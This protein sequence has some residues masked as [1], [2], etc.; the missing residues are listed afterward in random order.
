MEGAKSL[1]PANLEASKKIARHQNVEKNRH[2]AAILDAQKRC[3][4]REKNYC[5]LVWSGVPYRQALSEAY[6][7][8]WLD[9][10]DAQ[11]QSR[12]NEL[13]KG[14]A[15]ELFGLLASPLNELNLAQYSLDRAERMQM[16]T[17]CAGLALK[18]A[19]EQENAN[20]L[21]NAIRAINE[22]NKMD[23][24]H[25]AQQIDVKTVSINASV[26]ADL[27]AEQA[28]DLYLQA[29][30]GARLDEVIEV[31]ATETTYQPIDYSKPGSKPGSD[32]DNFE[33]D[34]VS[35]VRLNHAG[36]EDVSPFDEPTEEQVKEAENVMAV[37]KLST[38]PDI[39]KAIRPKR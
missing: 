13:M 35:G 16:L 9:K 24:Q 8:H 38:T 20:A 12:H 17:H 25:S 7:V 23:G 11:I 15:G 21:N 5:E 27:S 33:D 36:C 4:P 6:G 3:K 39:K 18:L 14:A 28:T 2:Q 31:E 10:T 29:M 26:S 22:L 30:K 34:E 1:Q 19:T 37:D 32:V